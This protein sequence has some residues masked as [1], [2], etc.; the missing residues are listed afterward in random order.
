MK[1]PGAAWCRVVSLLFAACCAAAGTPVS[2]QGAA[3]PTETITITP[4][5]G[6]TEAPGPE[7]A[8]PLPKGG[9]VVDL[10]TV[11]ADLWFRHQTLRQ[12]GAE[13]EAEALV[14]AAISFM[15]RE[16]LRSAPEIAEAFLA[17]ARR[18]RRD[19]NE[20]RAVENYV[21]ALRFDPDRPDAR[22]ALGI[23]ELRGGAMGTGVRDLSGGLRDLLR[24][25]ENLFYLAGAALLVLYLGA[26]V[27]LGTAVLLAAVRARGSFAH[28][29]LERLKGRLS[30]ASAPL[31]AAAILALPIALPV[32]LSWALSFWAALLLPYF[33]GAE[34]T[35]VIVTLVTLVFAGLFGA[36]VA[37]HL[38][39]A[40]DPTARALLQAAST[41]A[42]LRNEEALKRALREHPDD[43]VYPFLLG[44]AYR[45]GGR[46]E[47]AMAM[48][49]RVLTLDAKHARAMVNLG[50]LYALRQEFAQAHAL[51]KKAIEIDRNLVLAHFDGYL[52]YME[53]FEMESADA[54]LKEARRI[55]PALVDR[56]LLG[57]S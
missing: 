16:G 1:H 47:E 17:E 6:E 51:Y 32:P 48:Y 40:T 38:D 52:A 13:P 3:P 27:G 11:L 31:A 28:D 15:Q 19:G 24:D 30:P 10:R 45:L 54:A 2:A 14:D 29:L 20:A 4:G 36:A 33:G 46:P 43:P 12:R 26:V 37:W 41:G 49:R 5:A 23:Y 18:D 35:L 8:A 34:R 55:D 57:T 56:L 25:P 50:N 44:S 53:R 7:G 22:M 39:T 42:D 9:Q 21:L